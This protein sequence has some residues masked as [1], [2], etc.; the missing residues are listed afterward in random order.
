MKNNLYFIVALLV[1]VIMLNSCKDYLVPENKVTGGQ[2]ADEYFAEHPEALRTY[3]YSLLKPIA[4]RTDVFAKGTDL[5]MMTHQKT[6]SQFQSYILTPENEDVKSLYA[7]CYA[8]INAANAILFYDTE[9]K[10]ADEAIFIRS[11]MYYILSQQFGAVPYLTE[12]INNANRSYPRT[13]LNELYSGLIT[14]LTEI[15]NSSVLPEESHTGNASK[16]AAAA[17]LAKVYLAAAW[18]LGTTLTDAVAGTY[19]VNDVNGY[20]GKAAEWAEKAIGM[21][22]VHDLTTMTF[23]EKWS[24]KNEGNAEEIFS[25]QYDLAG[26]PGA[27]AEG[28]HGLQNHYG[29]Y[30]DMP[31]KTGGKYSDS[32]DGPTAKANRMWEKGDQ[33]Y[34]ATFMTTMYGYNGTD[35]SKG[36]FAYYNLDAAEQATLPIWKI[37]FPYTATEAEVT[38]FLT[39]NQ[40]RFAMKDAEGNVLQTLV[41]KAYLLGDKVTVW[42]FN[43]DGSVAKKTT[44]MSSFE[45]S[46]FEELD[47]VPSVK[48]WDDLNTIQS[49][50]NTNC[51]RD[52]VLLHLS[53]IYLVAAE[54]YLLGGNET[55]ALEYI[56]A[57]RTRAGLSAADF[58]NYEPEYATSALRPLDLLLDE[59]AKELYAEGQRWMDLRRTKQLV[60]YNVEYS[61]YI[62]DASQMQNNSGE[63]KWYRPIPQAE[64]NAND[65]ISEADQNPGY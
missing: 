31:A 15:A 57:V 46:V 10:Y 65:A 17:L 58:A 23:E 26:Y 56:N 12:Y 24:P 16:R 9:R 8:C 14:E 40:S 60:H 18:D 64:I 47:Y 49:N 20:F 27:V 30:F 37:Y 39:A 1:G 54:A 45:T 33:R 13:P 41:P 51:Y 29:S 53:D 38:A 19:T 63:Y 28:G 2:T 6:A 55:K 7:D 35:Y 25:V 50:V 52:I 42:E 43:E 3:A 62:T 22:A 32:E 11:Y 59:R 21:G 4:K 61:Y 36:Y 5:Y 44:N 34:A 48:K